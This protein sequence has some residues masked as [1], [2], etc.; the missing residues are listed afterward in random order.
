[1]NHSPKVSVVMAVHN[2]LPYLPEAVNSILGQSFDNFEF[3]VVDDASTD[4]SLDLLHRYADKRIRIISNKN[5]LDLGQSL[6]LGIDAAL[7]DYIARMDHDDISLPTRLAEQVRFLDTNIEIDLLGTGARTIGQIKQVWSYPK[8]DEGIRSEF[9]FNSALV[10]SSVMLRKSTFERH[11]LRYDPKFKR[12]QDYELWT[13]SAPYLRF[14]NLGQPLVRYRIHENQV[15]RQQAQQ[16]QDAASTV[17]ERELKLLGVNADEKEKRLHDLVSQWDFSTLGG[18]LGGT[19]QW[20]LKLWASNQT[21][22][23]YPHIAFGRTLERRWQAACRANVRRGLEAWW[24]YKRSPLSRL[25]RRNALTRVKF[26]GKALLR[27]L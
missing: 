9:V 1:M 11:K 20:F 22:G 17:R 2:G 26:F 16:Q 3:L 10:H 25:G 23:H 4:G 21:S 19:E 27:E 14:A 7:G 5:Q 13:R 24:T 15:G 18:E 6:N 12:A 8:D